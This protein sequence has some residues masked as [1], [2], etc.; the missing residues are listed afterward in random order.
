[1]PAQVG[2][3]ARDLQDA[4]VGAGG[5]A[6]ASDGHLERPLAGRVEGAF[7]ADEAGGHA[8][9]VVAALLL[10]GAG[11]LDAGADLGGGFGL[12]VAAEFLIGDGGDLD[13]N[14]DAVEEGA[15]DL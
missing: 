15:A 5:E 9:V 6:H 10:D 4:V 12:C 7:L 14:V 8:G 2:D 1:G 3:R 13:V 11:A